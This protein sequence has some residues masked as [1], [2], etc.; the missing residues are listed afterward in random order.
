M[1]TVPWGR[2]VAVLSR[3]APMARVP[4]ATAAPWGANGVLRGSP[5]ASTLKNIDFPYV[6]GGLEPEV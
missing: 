4:V 3:G 1:V 2:G 6:F 5:R